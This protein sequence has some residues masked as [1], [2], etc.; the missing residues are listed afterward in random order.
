MN[1]AGPFRILRVSPHFS[2]KPSTERGLIASN[3]LTIMV[4]LFL[5]VVAMCLTVPAVNAQ[6][7]EE[8]YLDFFVKEK[9]RLEVSIADY[10]QSEE[11]AKEALN[12]AVSAYGQAKAMERED[13]A[14]VA[15]QAMDIAQATLD[16]AR[17]RRLQDEARLKV[18]QEVLE[19][20]TTHQP[21][22][23]ATLLRG[24]IYKVSK[25]GRTRFDGKSLIYEGDEIQTGPN[26]FVE[27][28]LGDGSIIQLH[29]DSSFKAVALGEK[30]SIFDLLKGEIHV[31]FECIRHL[32]S[33]CGRTRYFFKGKGL[34]ELRGTEFLSSTSDNGSSRFIVVE[35]SVELS[36]PKTGRKVLVSTGEQVEI[37]LEGVIR[38]PQPVDLSSIKRWWEE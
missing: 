31:V 4:E 34:V 37:T 32:N 36:E 6:R 15:R 26:G 28:T 7:S 14:R 23:A 27:I 25:F 22:G 19:W 33:P 16:R 29:S 35:G 1:F 5:C 11:L 9:A 24:E 10:K 30:E 2:R 12:Q 3:A 8:W 18:I 20:R 21:T 38:N 17:Q 13:A